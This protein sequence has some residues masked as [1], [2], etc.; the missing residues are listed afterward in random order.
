MCRRCLH[1]QRDPIVLQDAGAPTSDSST[2]PQPGV[3]R[4]LKISIGQQTRFLV[5]LFFK[6]STLTCTSASIF[7]SSFVSFLNI[8]PDPTTASSLICWWMNFKCG[9]DGTFSPVKHLFV[10]SLLKDILLDYSILGNNI[11]KIICEYFWN[12]LLNSNYYITFF[13]RCF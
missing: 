3:S 5:C 10:S 11:V 4:F 7:W 1:F 9:T 6:E 8:L 2:H 12:V 13:D